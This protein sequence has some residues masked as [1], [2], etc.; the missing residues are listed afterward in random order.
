MSDTNTQ[1]AGNTQATGEA[2]T[3]VA[4]A[5]TEATTSAATVATES[6]ATSQQEAKGQTATNVE[7]DA[8]S[9]ESDTEATGDKPAGAPD[10]Y[11][12]T[13]PEGKGFDPEVIEA[14]STVAKELGLPQDSAQKILD[15]I[16]PKVAERFEARQTE[17]LAKFKTDLVEQVKSDKELGGEKLNENL[18]VAKKAV[19]A[20]GT[21]ELRK[22]LDDSG[23]GNH[24]ELIRAF[25]KAGKA[26]SEDKFVQGGR[27]PAKGET[28]AAKA[29]YP[30]QPA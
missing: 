10:K 30:N 7:T 22:L 16:A 3:A 21:P 24:P 6:T 17:A 23:L 12:F 27:Q 5:T 26:I 28:N 18:A 20:F 25:Y 29:L 13:A 9:A 8:A 11:E 14:Y 15:A 19:D 2:Q 1:T 4:A